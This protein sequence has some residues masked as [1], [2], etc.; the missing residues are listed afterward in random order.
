[1]SAMRATGIRADLPRVDR[2]E[3]LV[4]AMRR[5]AA[6]DRR[7]WKWLAAVALRAVYGCQNHEIG[8]AID[9]HPSH[10]GRQLPAVLRELRTH[11][12]S[13]DLDDDG[14]AGGDGI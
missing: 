12:V 7:R 14:F 8:Q 11:L 1:M 6:R 3:S 13:P 5:Y 9:Q 10:V 4:G 2:D